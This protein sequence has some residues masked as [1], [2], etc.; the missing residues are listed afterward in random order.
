L[1]ATFP[2]KEW[3]VETVKQLAGR[4]LTSLRKVDKTLR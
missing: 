3:T 1:K 4:F 2:D